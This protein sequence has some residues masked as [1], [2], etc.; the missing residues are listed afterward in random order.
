MLRHFQRYLSDPD[1]QKIKCVLKEHGKNRA[2]SQMI[3]SLLPNGK[4]T[5]MHFI[6]YFSKNKKNLFDY[7]E[8]KLSKY[9][10]KEL[11]PIMEQY[12]EGR[13]RVGY[14]CSILIG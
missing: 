10:L 7:I 4:A 6:E 3:N 9:G 5:L 12:K 14:L 8:I 13:Q 11:L 2:I 1:T